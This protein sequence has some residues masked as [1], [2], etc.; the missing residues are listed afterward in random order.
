[1]TTYERLLSELGD[2]LG[3]AL[4]SD[5]DGIADLSVEDRMVTLRADATGERELT[6]FTAVASAPEGGFPPQTL[7]RALAMNLFGKDVVGHHLG[8]FASTLYL[9][10]TIPLADLQCEDLADRLLVLARLAG[11]LAASLENGAAPASAAP[12]TDDMP[13]SF[14]KV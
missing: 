9:S 10:A 3:I 6:A 14:L 12:A 5:S 13:S 1:M 2:G 7:K 8:L 4:K 11:T